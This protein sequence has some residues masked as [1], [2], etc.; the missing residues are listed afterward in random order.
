MT[1][2]QANSQSSWTTL[3]S[4][5]L[6]VAVI[7]FYICFYLYIHLHD[8]ES[9]YDLEPDTHTQ[10]STTWLCWFPVVW[11]IA[12]FDYFMLEVVRREASKVWTRYN[13]G[14]AGSY[15]TMHASVHENE[16]WNNILSMWS[17]LCCHLREVAYLRCSFLVLSASPHLY[18][19]RSAPVGSSLRDYKWSVMPTD[20][21]HL[22]LVIV[23]KRV[24]FDQWSHVISTSDVM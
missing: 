5:I 21:L 11:P 20:H 22:W 17:S 16:M 8:N 9:V 14:K 4:E 18:W 3:Y 15:S 13:G 7:Q 6:L 1:W 10:K 12:W 23:I 2:F 19:K 24:E